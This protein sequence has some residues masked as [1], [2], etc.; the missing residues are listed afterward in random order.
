MDLQKGEKGFGFGTKGHPE[1]ACPQ[2]SITQQ[3][4]A[5]NGARDLSTSFVP[6]SKAVRFVQ[7]SEFLFK[8]AICLDL[9]GATP[10]GAGV[11]HPMNPC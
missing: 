8:G 3:L 11:L 7:V 2:G 5:T 4:V 1:F 10:T 9:P 6:F